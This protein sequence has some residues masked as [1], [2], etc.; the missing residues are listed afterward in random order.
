MIETYVGGHGVNSQGIAPRSSKTKLVSPGG[1]A[2][3]YAGEN[4]FDIN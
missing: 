3:H 2:A 4:S 1:K